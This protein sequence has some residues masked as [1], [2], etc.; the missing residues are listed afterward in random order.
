MDG[1]NGPLLSPPKAKHCILSGRLN[2]V[3][4]YT[5]LDSLSSS[6]SSSRKQKPPLSVSCYPPSH[7]SELTTHKHLSPFFSELQFFTLDLFLG[8]PTR[9]ADQEAGLVE[10][11]WLY[12]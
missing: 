1:V 3:E 4:E 9:K 7:P 2:R 8:F 6:L 5:V 11:C 10:S 12:W